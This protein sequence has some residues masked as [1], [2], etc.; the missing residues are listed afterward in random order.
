LL[1]AVFFRIAEPR[2]EIHRAPWITLLN[3]SRAFEKTLKR[4]AER[5][6]W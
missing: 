6:S 5:A 3:D 1:R 4:F 2:L